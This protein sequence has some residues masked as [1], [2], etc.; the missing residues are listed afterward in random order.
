M[1]DAERRA[2]LADFLRAL[3]GRCSPEALGLPTG[4]RRHTRGLR[5]EEVATLAGVGVTWY[6]WLEQGR[7]IHVSEQVLDSLARVFQLSAAE[8]QHLYTLARQQLPLPPPT[9][10]TTVSAH[11]QHLLDH[12]EW[13]AYVTTRQWTVV[14]WNTAACRVIADFGCLS[15]RERNLVWLMFTDPRQRA[16]IVNWEDQAKGL[17]ALFRASSA[18]DIGDAWHT[19]FVADLMAASPEFQA[20]WP[21]HEVQATYSP[22]KIFDHPEV[23]RMVF[24]PLNLQIADAP[25]LRLVIQTPLAETDTAA[26]LKRLLAGGVHV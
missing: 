17:L 6:T 5:R 22:R 1:R 11:V 16:L 10:T 14:A 26:K 4:R 12:L 19:A 21:R 9:P 24:Q 7:D 23:G 3:R 15:D 13:P 25:D 20:W 18:V 8:R 2:A